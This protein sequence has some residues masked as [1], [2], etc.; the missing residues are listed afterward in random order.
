MDCLCLG[1]QMI[2]VGSAVALEIARDKTPDQINTLAALLTVIGDEL[3]L[4]ATLK[5][6]CQNGS[7]GTNG[8]LTL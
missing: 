3:A 7:E 4:L 2:A 8:N 1:G 6:S 5:S